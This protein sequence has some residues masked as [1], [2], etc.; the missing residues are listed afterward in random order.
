[1]E[2]L[3]RGQISAIKRSEY[4]GQKM[5]KLQF[6]SEDPE[7]GF[8]ITEVKVLDEHSINELEKGQ[9]V[10]IPIAMSA[11]EGKIFYRTNGKIQV[12]K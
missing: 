6:L 12:S 3:I 4:Q 5:T 11:M 7:K 2:L 9:K 10:I 8:S 1:M